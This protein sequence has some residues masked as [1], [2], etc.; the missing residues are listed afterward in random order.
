MSRASILLREI[1]LRRAQKPRPVHHVPSEL[2]DYARSIAAWNELENDNFIPDPLGRHR[3][4]AHLLSP[5]PPAR[6]KRI[7]GRPFG[8]IRLIDRHGVPK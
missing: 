3:E 1:D 2:E 4:P 6:Y 7:P 8:Q 5:A